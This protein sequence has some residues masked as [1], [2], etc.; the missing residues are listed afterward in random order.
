MVFTVA[1]GATMDII[2]HTASAAVPIEEDAALLGRCC[3]DINVVGSLRNA[4]R[5]T[6]LCVKCSSVQIRCYLVPP[7]AG[8]HSGECS[9]RTV[10][11]GDRGKSKCSSC[12]QY[13][14]LVANQFPGSVRV[15]LNH[16]SLKVRPGLEPIWQVDNLA[17][18]AVLRGDN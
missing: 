11:L 15:S 16:N 12:L 4:K 1:C 2:A 10:I 14:V 7:N 5:T 13:Y 3:E 9:K 6:C 8:V 18:S 17:G